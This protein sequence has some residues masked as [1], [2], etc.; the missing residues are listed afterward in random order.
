[1][2]ALKL[3]A[4]GLRQARTVYGEAHRS[5]LSRQRELVDWA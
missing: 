5:S 3:G 1:M 2:E 4:S